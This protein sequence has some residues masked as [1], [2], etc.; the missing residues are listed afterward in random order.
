MQ[1]ISIRSP[2]EDPPDLYFAEEELEKLRH[3]LMR[4]D[5]EQ[6]KID[7][8]TALKVFEKIGHTSGQETALT[9][10]DLIPRELG[11]LES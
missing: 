5:F 6:P 1:E 9:V 2:A 3:T 8:K 4:G 10:P 7:A 11:L